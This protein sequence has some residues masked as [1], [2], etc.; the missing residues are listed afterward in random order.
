MVS[1]LPDQSTHPIEKGDLAIC[2]G[3]E[4]RDLVDKW[5]WESLLRVLSQRDLAGRYQ[6]R[7]LLERWAGLNSGSY[8]QYRSRRCTR[9]IALTAIAIRLSG[10]TQG[11]S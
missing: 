10:V 1:V 6:T 4:R 2:P 5:T 3:G 9:Q 7:S 11:L 8:A